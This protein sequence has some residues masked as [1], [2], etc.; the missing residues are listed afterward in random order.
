MMNLTRKQIKAL[1]EVMSSDNSRPVLCYLWTENT[2]DGS[3]FIATDSYKAV[4]LKTHHSQDKQ[5]AV[6]RDEL[7]KW[8]KLAK[9]SDILT[10]EDILAM[11]TEQDINFPKVPELL[12]N[13]TVVAPDTI[14]FN[15]GYADTLERIASRPLYYKINGE[16]APM[17]ATLDNNTY[18][19]MPI[20]S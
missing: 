16:L 5:L 15:A 20:K 9:T 1:L 10:E 7:T 2:E 18:I 19:L 13:I 4:M 6:H 17:V 11:M 8:Y 3:Y 12:K 14:G